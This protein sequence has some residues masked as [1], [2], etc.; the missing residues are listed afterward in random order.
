METITLKN[1]FLEDILFANTVGKEYAANPEGGDARFNL[2]DTDRVTY[3]E[4]VETLR[5]E[6]ADPILILRRSSDG[7]YFGTV[8]NG[9]AAAEGVRWFGIAD[10][11]ELAEMARKEQTVVTVNFAFA[12]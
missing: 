3:F 10:N 2:K 8:F 5:P 6:D 9:N 4:H 7:T 11:I 1:T 12:E